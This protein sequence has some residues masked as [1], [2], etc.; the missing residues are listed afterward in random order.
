M[1]TLYLVLY[2]IAC[3][4][5]GAYAFINRSLLALGLLAWVLVPT[6]HL[7]LG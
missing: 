6:L 3:L 2:I 7:L 5:I 1:H 4:S